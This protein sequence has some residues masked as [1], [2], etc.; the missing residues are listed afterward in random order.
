MLVLPPSNPTR[1]HREVEKVG[2]QTD[3]QKEERVEESV[4]AGKLDCASPSGGSC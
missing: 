1:W 4:V 2:R 3:G